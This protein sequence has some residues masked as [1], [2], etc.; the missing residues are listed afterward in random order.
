MSVRFAWDRTRYS[1]MTVPTTTMVKP[2]TSHPSPPT[3]TSPALPTTSIPGLVIAAYTSCPGGTNCVYQYDVYQL[4]TATS[5]GTISDAAYGT[6]TLY[7]YPGCT[8]ADAMFT[9]VGA[10]KETDLPSIGPFAMDGFRG[11]CY[12]LPE[13]S[14][15]GQL[16]PAATIECADSQFNDD[17]VECVSCYDID[18]TDV[19]PSPGANLCGAASLECDISSGDKI[20]TYPMYYCYFQYNVEGRLLNVSVGH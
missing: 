14:F 5:V 12:V 9:T 6:S 7:A 20:F 15:D 1:G 8:T 4:N 19:Y 2:T 17:R 16:I 13:W 11:T 10:A 3:T 18:D